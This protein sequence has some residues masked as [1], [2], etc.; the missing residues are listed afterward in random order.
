MKSVTRLKSSATSSESKLINELIKEYLIHSGYTAT[1]KCFYSHTTGY[2]ALIKGASAE[3][4]AA[5]HSFDSLEGAKSMENRQCI[6]N[7]ISDIQTLVASGNIDTALAL[8]Q[9]AFP[10]VLENRYIRLSLM[11]LQFVEM[12]TSG[13]VAN[14]TMILISK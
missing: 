7:I 10:R 11:C 8:I 9:Q 2:L 14:G 6:I 5:Q 4:D 3:L 1:A 13:T 12:T